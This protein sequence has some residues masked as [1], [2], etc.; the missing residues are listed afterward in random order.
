MNTIEL[1]KIIQCDQVLNKVFIGIFAS[2]QLNHT[3]RKKPTAMIVNTDPTTRPGQHWVAMYF[4]TNGTVD[5]FDSYGLTLYVPEFIKFM[6]RNSI[7]INYN[8]VRLQS[9]E[10]E[11]C[12][13]YCLYFLYFRV[14]NFS[15]SNIVHRFNL[16]DFLHNDKMVCKFINKQFRFRHYVCCNVQKSLSYVKN[17]SIK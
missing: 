16:S 3:V 12:G 10:S 4:D 7:R 14:R 1:R 15:M 5:Y 2:N 11:V 17:K 8:N 13:I 6:N 9:S